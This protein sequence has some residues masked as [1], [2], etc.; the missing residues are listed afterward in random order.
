M[1]SPNHNPKLPILSIS[2]L[3]RF[4]P[5]LSA[6]G[7]VPPPRSP[8]DQPRDIYNQRIHDLQTAIERLNVARDQVK[9]CR[10]HAGTLLA[11]KYGIDYRACRKWL[12]VIH[13]VAKDLAVWEQADIKYHGRRRD[14]EDEDES[15]GDLGDVVE[16][17]DEADD[18][19][20]DN[21]AEDRR[22]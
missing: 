5:S 10:E 7:K 18:D 15:S 20:A 16:G 19:V 8:G 17:E 21:N 12:D 14:D 4:P 2:Y 22:S 1:G 3:S 11:E 9:D 13:S 6:L